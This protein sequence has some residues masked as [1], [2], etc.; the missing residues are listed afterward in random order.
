LTRG[1]PL[2]R[3]ESR[4]AGVYHPVEPDIRRDPV[5]NI[6]HSIFRENRN[7]KVLL[8]AFRFGRGGEKS[9]AALYGPGQGNLS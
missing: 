2:P 9:S 1:S 5:P 3:Y 7:L 6:G 4:N 8:D